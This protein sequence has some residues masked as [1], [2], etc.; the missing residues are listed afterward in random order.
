[1]DAAVPG[2]AREEEVLVVASG[3]EDVIAPA[4]VQPAEFRPAAGRSRR[5]VDDVG[6]GVRGADQGGG[7]GAGGRAVGPLAARPGG[8]G[9]G[10]C[11]HCWW[12]GGPRRGPCG[13]GACCS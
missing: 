7:R 8:P 13:W 4:G 12:C 5:V 9:R 10:C 11:C 3:A 1:E 6:G 2:P